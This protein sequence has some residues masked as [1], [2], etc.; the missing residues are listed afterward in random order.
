MKKS[1][2]V[3][4]KE[5]KKENI[6]NEDITIENNEE[7]AL[8]NSNKNKKY[9]GYGKRLLRIVIFMII[10][11][12]IALV[13]LFKIISFISTNKEVFSENSISNYA[14]CLNDSDYY[15]NSCLEEDMEY[16]S[17]ITNNI[18]YTYTYN[19]LYD[20]PIKKDYKY[21]VDG[22]L[23]IY[24]QDNTEQVLYKKGYKFNKEKEY[25]NT[26]NVFTISD[27]VSIPYNEIYSLVVDYNNKY[28]IISN[29]ILT[30]NFRVNDKVA[31]SLQIPV[32]KQTFTVEKKDIQN[33]KT[34]DRK[35]KETLTK[36][37]II[38]FVSLIISVLI[39]IICSIRLVLFLR[40]YSV[41]SNR[42]R[43]EVD[44]ILKNYDRIIVEVNDVS[45]ILEG[46]KII[47]INDFIELVDLRDTL[48]KPILHLKVNEIKN[49]FYVEDV[50]KVYEY[51]IKESQFE[52][53]E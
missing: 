45:G 41:K 29:A 15:N 9:V 49:A 25:T 14:V 1:D 46:K 13:S 26:G 16:L 6:E 52:N 31:S 7:V 20:E 32:G 3:E 38:N 35:L 40:K 34:V 47:T 33:Q 10:F 19:A 24:S 28:S 4:N 50:D 27:S 51:I 23:K 37:L 39:F 44:N 12:V 2:K 17:A 8:E 36:D 48:D 11:I 22:E 5:I 21:I 30:I 43:N 42:Y 53:K 18:T